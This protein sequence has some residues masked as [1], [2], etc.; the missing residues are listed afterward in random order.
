[1]SRG[2]GKTQREAMLCVWD[3]AKL[4]GVAGGMPLAE[5]KRC[6]STDRSNA[7]RAIRGLIA[8]DL[9]EEVRDEE[10]VR[11]ARLTS[12]GH[13]A[14]WLA[15]YPDDR[16]ALGAVP[17]R[18]LHLDLSYDEDPLGSSE[19]SWINAAA[20]ELAVSDN[21]PESPE[22]G[23]PI[24]GGIPHVR[25]AASA[26]PPVSDNGP[27]SHERGDAMQMRQCHANAAAFPDPAVSDNDVRGGL[28]VME[29]VAKRAQEVLERL[30]SEAE[31][32]T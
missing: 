26:D 2:I 29:M 6:I 3:L 17:S 14:C 31:E 18:P 8:R 25:P 12:D 9:L 13:L 1:M 28:S 22:R 21:G 19:P 32:R 7:R 11:R 27:S 15:A 20:S 10:G 5:L 4:E 16:L 24:Q 23:D 30:D